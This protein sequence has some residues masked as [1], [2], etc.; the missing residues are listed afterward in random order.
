MAGKQASEG[1]GVSGVAGRYGSALFELARDEGRIDEVA[2]DL[3]SF[4]RML[5]D[6]ADLRRLIRSPVFSAEDQTRA[7][8]AVLGQA[9]IGGYAANL[10]RV[11]AAKRRLFVLPDMIRA[12]RALVAK[13][14]GIVAAEVRLAEEPSPRI[15]DDIKSALRDMAGSDVDVDVKIDPSL[16]GGLVVKVGSRMVDASL[17]TKLNSIRIAM[18]EAR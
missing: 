6:S 2:R 13:S 16:I 14:K 4:Q 9:G 18:K 7:I 8:E 15:M 5:D 10:I 3:D 1:P 17:K 11:V 12:Y